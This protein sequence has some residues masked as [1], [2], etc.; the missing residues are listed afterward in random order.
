MP[1]GMK[2]EKKYLDGKYC[3]DKWINCGSIGKAIKVMVKEGVLN[4]V[5]GKAPTPP[6]VENS[7]WLWVLDNL[8]EA[9]PLIRQSWRNDGAVFSDLE[10]EQ[11]WGKLVVGKAQRFLSR[12]QWAQFIEKHSYL[13]P[14]LER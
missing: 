2:K 5:T 6:G 4:P 3:F 9:K 1:P 13:K 7:A 12:G 11:L 8:P 10:F 14:Y